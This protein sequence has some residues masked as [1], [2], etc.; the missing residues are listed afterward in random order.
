VEDT[1]LYWLLG[2]LYN[3]Q[4]E[5]STAAEIFSRIVWV[6]RYDGALLMKHRQVVQEAKT[7]PESIVPVLD[8]VPSPS[9]PLSEKPGWLP[10]RNQLILAGAVAGAVIAGLVFLQVREVKKRKRRSHRSRH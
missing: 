5:A 1:R 8:Q 10:T 4:G 6:H 9:T 7:A 3:A 2:E